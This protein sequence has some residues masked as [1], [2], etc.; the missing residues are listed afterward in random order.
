M[1][2]E[3]TEDKD[4]TLTK[5]SSGRRLLEALL[6]LIALFAV[7]LMAALLSFNP[8][9]PSWS[10]TAWH[11]PIHNLGGIPGAW[12]A[13]TLFFIFGVMAYTI[14][15]IIV[16][17][18]WFAWRHQASD[19]YVDYFAVSL[20]IIG[21]LALILTSCGLAAI[22]AD[23]I[24]YFA[25]G[26]VIGSLLSTTLQP[27]L[28][29]SG[30]TLTLLCIWAAGLTLF[31]GWSWVS[32]AEKLGG[33]LLNILTFAS[34][35]TR[36]DDTWVD[37]EEYEDEDAP[38]DAADGKPHETRRARI[39]R[40]ALARRKRLAEKFTNPLGRHTDA[41]LF[42]GKRM[43]DEDEI[44]YSARGVVA[45]PN[46]VLFSGNRATLPEYD[47]LDPLL[48]GHS[49]TEPVAAAAA[50][51]TA[52]QAWSAPVDPLLQTSPVTNTVMEPPAQAVA[53]Q[54][55]PGAQTGDAVTAPAPEGYPQP[56]QYTQP[57]VQQ[58]YESWQQPVVE[59]SPQPQGFTAEQNW[60]PEPAYQPEP[61]QQ[62][63][64]Q[65]ESTF[66]QNATFQQPA[67]EQPPVVEPEP[68]VEEVKPTRPPLYYFEEVEEKRARE[69][70][71]LAAW[72][73]P[74]PEPVQEPE[75]VKPT[76]PT[77]ASIPP[78]E[79]VAAVAPLA[80][81]VKSAALGAGC[82]CRSSCL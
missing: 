20:R 19:E 59:E 53:W 72:Y 30:G 32:I 36:R 79:S 40:G 5:L 81:G 14:P 45:D 49:V 46:D 17:G 35:R 55:V 38:F 7:W 73:Q 31:T 15:V 8:S 24:W 75:R 21:V 27:L 82:R 23:D 47:E 76:M 68:V 62:P 70:E 48:N 63:V 1:S 22:N 77:A 78:V 16:G 29:S 74:I 69:R 12:L 2:Q 67:V 18:C 26:G 33:W 60:Q 13:D 43:D 57:P 51:T 3:Y 42:S 37:D 6:I 39:L 71:Q 64:Y 11:E 10:Q 50:A 56:A 41:A 28:H 4:V 9:D 58:Q 54:P 34:N 52:A 66:Q 65:P 25:S 80:A 61:V 44:E